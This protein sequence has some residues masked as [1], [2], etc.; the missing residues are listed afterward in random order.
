MAQKAAPSLLKLDVQSA[1]AKPKA[2]GAAKGQGLTA[3][4]ADADAIL[5]AILPPSTGADGKTQG[6]R[7]SSTP[8]TKIDVLALQVRAECGSMRA[9]L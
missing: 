1:L 5:E 8:A 6:L 4:N 2:A 3:A 9:A 7:V